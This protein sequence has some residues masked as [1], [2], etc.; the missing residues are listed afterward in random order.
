[1]GVLAHM[2][3]RQEFNYSISEGLSKASVWIL[4]LSLFLAVLCELLSGLKNLIS[5]VK[6]Y[7][8]YKKAMK[9]SVS[10]PKS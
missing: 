5:E 9:E 1:M 6:R 2:S 3:F 8:K 4:V 10:T 7:I